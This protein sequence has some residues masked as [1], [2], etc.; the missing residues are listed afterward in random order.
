MA[1]ERPS[2]GAIGHKWSVEWASEMMNPAGAALLRLLPVQGHQLRLN[3]LS[4]GPAYD[5]GI[6]DKRVDAVPLST[7]EFGILA[8]YPRGLPRRA[9]KLT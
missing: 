7:W 8:R 5:F 6:F 3:L 9:A 4:A 2:E 1:R